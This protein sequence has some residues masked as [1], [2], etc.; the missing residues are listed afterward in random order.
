MSLVGHIFPLGYNRANTQVRG[1]TT[2][3]G[4]AGAGAQTESP[5][6][7]GGGGKECLLQNKGPGITSELALGDG[8]MC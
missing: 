4:K 6:L 3:T 1:S 5:G 8:F 2:D 7:M